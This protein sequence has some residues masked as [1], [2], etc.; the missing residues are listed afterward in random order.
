MYCFKATLLFLSFRWEKIQNLTKEGAHLRKTNFGP[1]YGKVTE[2]GKIKNIYPFFKK[3]LRVIKKI[4]TFQIS[5]ILKNLHRH[6]KHVFLVMRGLN[7]MG[8]ATMRLAHEQRRARVMACFTKASGNREK[9]QYA[10]ITLHSAISESHSH[11]L[12]FCVACT[13]IQ[14]QGSLSSVSSP[15]ANQQPAIHKSGTSGEVDRD[16]PVVIRC[17]PAHPLPTHGNLCTQCSSYKPEGIHECSTF[18]FIF[19]DN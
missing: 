15:S 6:K 1:I 5:F 2:G 9:L 16:W 14:H 19:I 7:I 3:L 8:S 13:H 17:T 12:R 4:K 18:N 10:Y 11:P